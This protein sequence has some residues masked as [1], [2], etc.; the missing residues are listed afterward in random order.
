MDLED[1]LVSNNLLPLGA[2][3]YLLFCVK[4]TGWGWDNLIEEA[5]NIIDKYNKND[6]LKSLA[7]YISNRNK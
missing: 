7:L 6:F 3:F 2:L 5:I 4:K 1:F